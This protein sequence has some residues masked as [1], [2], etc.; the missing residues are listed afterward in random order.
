VAGMRVAR[1]AGRR[2]RDRA[3]RLELGLIRHEPVPEMW[4]AIGYEV[5]FLAGDII[6]I[7]FGTGLRWGEIAA[8]RPCEINLETGC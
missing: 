3:R 4:I 8:L 1:R 7:A 2:K 6:T 5:S